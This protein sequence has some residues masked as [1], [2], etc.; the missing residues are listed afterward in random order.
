MGGIAVIRVSGEQAFS[1]CDK[2]F[3]SPVGK[4]LTEQKTATAHFGKVV[5]EGSV[6]DEVIATVFRAPRSF[7]GEDTVE[8]SCHG[9]PYIQQQILQALI[10]CG[11]SMAQ[12]G[13]FTLRAYLNGKMDLA[14]AEAVADLIASSTRA[15]HRVAM[16]QMRG[17]YSNDIRS[18][19]DK[20]LHFASMLELELDFSDEEVE[21][22]NRDELKK[23]LKEILSVA[24]KLTASFSVGNAIKKGI[25]VA[26]VGAPN[27]G[28]STLLNALLND[29]KALVSDVEGTTRDAIEDTV[30][31]GGV[32]FRFIDT[33]GIRRSADLVEN[34]GIERTFEKMSKAAIVILL[35]DA[36]RP[37]TF[38]SVADIQPQLTAE[39]QL[40]VAV[41]KIDSEFSTLN[42]QFSTLNYF[43]LS[44]KN[45]AGL[46][47]L[48]KELLRLS[49]IPD[50]L[51]SDSIVSNVRHYEA[52][53]HA[54]QSL[55]Q[56]LN[57]LSIGLSEELVA[58]EIREATRHLSSI[59]GD[60]S[61]ND[62][63]GNIFEKF[64]IGK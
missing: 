24:E 45:K 10:G 7:T 34:L 59:I 56:A 58:F 36:T 15:M 52:F 60:I 19:R 29:E 22:A 51:D 14:Q 43:H 53:V 49:A 40:I 2:I 6:V 54:Q 35:L 9:S 1:I 30:M 62:I 18:L 17:G 48:E 32:L 27:V 26:I 37:E 55:E 44:A 3:V 25:P 64:C 12:G 5:V 50:S 47:E 61:D 4:K 13:E 21:F 41:N 33:A 8:I 63:L 23:L 16:Q 39:Q 57:G 46:H 28:K 11:A 31:L 20:L 38:K 42:S